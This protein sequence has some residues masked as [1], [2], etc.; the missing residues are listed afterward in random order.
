MGGVVV[1]VFL[2]LAGFFLPHHGNSNINT[3][4]TV[5]A[6]VT[7][8]PSVTPTDTPTVTP[9]DTP[10]VTPIVTVEPSVSPTPTATVSPTVTPAPDEDGDGD[11]DDILHVKANFHALWGLM[12]AAWHHERNEERFKTKHGIDRDNE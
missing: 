3:Q 10:T 6:D 7:V 1:S 9:T 4:T 12:N 11:K 8:D 5:Q 2:M